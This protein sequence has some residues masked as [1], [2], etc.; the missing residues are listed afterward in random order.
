MAVSFFVFFGNLLLVDYYYIS[1]RW[2]TFFWACACICIAVD[3]A[4]IA[5]D[6]K[7]SEKRAEDL[8]NQLT[9]QKSISSQ[10]L[11]KLDENH[12][13]IMEIRTML[14]H[15][16]HAPF[17]YASY[18]RF[19]PKKN[20]HR[21]VRHPSISDVGPVQCR[22]QDEGASRISK[23]ESFTDIYA[24]LALENEMLAAG[25][26]I[27]EKNNVGCGSQYSRTSSLQ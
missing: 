10:M 17:Q 5:V 26:G 3:A 6:L 14:T 19:S 13:L 9:A 7:V 25:L 21:H 4:V 18:Q 11:R 15:N 23:P 22:S 20:D 27:G 24:E 12:T 8:A 2:L 1:L 16:N